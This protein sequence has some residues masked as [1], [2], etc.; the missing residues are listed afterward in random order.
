MR[1]IGVKNQIGRRIKRI[2]TTQSIDAERFFDF[3]VLRNQS[4]TGLKTKARINPRT[5]ERIIGRI[6]KKERTAR[7][8][9]IIAIKIL[10]MYIL[11][12]VF[13]AINNIGKTK[14]I[15]FSGENFISGLP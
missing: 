5:I 4:Y 12:I 13:S 7:T 15:K 14:Y 10:L 6:N 3:T 9:T 2:N 8:N 1:R 11:S